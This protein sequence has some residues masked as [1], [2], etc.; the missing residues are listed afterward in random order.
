MVVGRCLQ[1]VPPFVLVLHEQLAR[2]VGELLGLGHHPGGPVL[3]IAELLASL[4]GQL[5]RPRYFAGGRVRPVAH[6]VQLRRRSG[7]VP[8]HQFGRLAA[9]RLA[10][11]RDERQTHARHTRN[12]RRDDDTGPGVPAGFSRTPGTDDVSTAH[13]VAKRGFRWTNSKFGFFSGR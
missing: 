4:H 11:C 6:R 8:G 12:H 7:Y 5:M 10:D 3:Q 9:G 13:A 2:V 1:L